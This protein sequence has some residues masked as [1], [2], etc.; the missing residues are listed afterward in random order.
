MAA[1]DFASKAGFSEITV[2]GADFGYT[3]GKSYAKGTYLDIL[4]KAG[5]NKLRTFETT[6]SALQ[7]RSPLTRISAKKTTT[8]LLE[9]YRISFEEWADQNGFTLE[10]DSEIY[11]LHKR[12]KDKAVAMPLNQSSIDIVRLKSVTKEFP[13]HKDFRTEEYDRSSPFQ[14]AFLPFIAYLRKK[15][16]YSSRPYKALQN[17][18]L[19]DF[20]LYTKLL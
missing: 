9:S 1:V 5:E 12:E 18:A 11:T 10:N 20:V 16:Q 3:G 7:Y 2:L 14:T 17:L 13:A 6:F 8:K 15:E 19:D 4:F